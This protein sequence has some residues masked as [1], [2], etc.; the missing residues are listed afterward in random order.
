[1]SEVSQGSG[2]WQASDLKWY[3]PELHAD[4]VAPLPP[5]PTLPT[6]ETAAPPP[7]SGQRPRRQALIAA[8][9]AVVVIL[10]AAAITGYLLRQPST[11]SQ[12]PTAS[13]TIAQPPTTTSRTVAPVAEAALDG[14][15]L[16][17]DQINAVMGA[18]AMTVDATWTAMND[19]SGNMPD[20][21]CL[22]L[23]APFQAAVYAGSGWSAIRSEN[24]HEPGENNPHFVLQ[25]VVLFSSAQEA[26]AFF[27]ASAQSWPACS[28]RQY[29]VVY[30]NAPNGVS[31]VGPV[32]NTNGTLS[33]TDSLVVGGNLPWACQRALTARNNVVIDVSTC[34]H[35]TTDQGVNIAHQIAA[36]VPS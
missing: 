14:L 16:S 28:N 13:T 25:G 18:T 26:G 36:K 15:L 27:T 4:Y 31:A 22:P 21:D 29:T 30:S 17:P 33:A 9:A 7:P 10:A 11:T 24:V 2:W 34:S 5:P 8:V 35:N 19:L 32:S 23:Y 12:P 1:M 20:K 3:P 6:P